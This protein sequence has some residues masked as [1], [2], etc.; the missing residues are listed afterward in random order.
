MVGLLSTV[1][2]LLVGEEQATANKAKEAAAIAK[3]NLMLL[4]L[5]NYQLIY[6]V[7]IQR[8]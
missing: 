3:N 6:V 2:A 5:K 7:A 1:Y 8:A 4:I